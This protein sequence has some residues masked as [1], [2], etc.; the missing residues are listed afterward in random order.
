MTVAIEHATCFVALP[1]PSVRVNSGLS[2][3]KSPPSGRI[4]VNW[5]GASD[6][7]RRTFLLVD[8][9]LASVSLRSRFGKHL[10]LQTPI[11]EWCT[12][13]EKVQLIDMSASSAF[14]VKHVGFNALGVDELPRDSTVPTYS[15]LSKRPGWKA[16][17]SC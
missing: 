13:D 2:S 8:F 3:L 5:E 1:M 11:P 16:E 4:S 14:I 15:L 7:S 10:S 12:R 17:E 9:G 6:E